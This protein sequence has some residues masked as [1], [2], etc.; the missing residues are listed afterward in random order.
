MEYQYD[1]NKIVNYLSKHKDKLPELYKW[2]FKT[3][4][5][6]EFGILTKKELKKLDLKSDFEKAVSLK[7]LVSQKFDVSK[8][9]QNLLNKLY[10]WIIK[11]W[12]G[13]RA[14]DNNNTLKLINEFLESEKPDFKRIASTSKVGSFINPEKY[15]IYDSR[16]AYALNWIILSQ[17][18][19]KYFFPI[20]NGRN[21]KMG[22]FDI[23]VLIRLKNIKKYQPEIQEDLDNKRFI[24]NRDKHVFISQND[25]Y[26]ELQKLIKNIH[27]ELWRGDAEKK[28]KL[29]YTEMLLFS[30]ADRE[31]IMDIINSV[32]IKNNIDLQ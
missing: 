20:P 11:D 9:D 1:I 8:T 19:G 13:I 28:D 3:D 27:S 31:I 5:L 12:G 30:I 18:A 14:T 6:L 29:F 16:V 32:L 23:N 26:S 25:A 24:Y 15:I 21:T 4:K 7:N 17:E 2:P 22:A 10:L